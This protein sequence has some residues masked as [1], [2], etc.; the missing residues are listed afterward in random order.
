MAIL[1]AVPVVEPIA[2]ANIKAC[3]LQYRQIA[4]CTNRGKTLRKGAIELPCIDMVGD[5][6]NELGAAAW[7]VTSRA[8]RMGGVEPIQD[9]SSVQE[10]VDQ[11][12]QQRSAARQC[13]AI[14]AEPQRRQSERRTSP[15]P[16]LCP[17]S[18][19]HCAMARSSMVIAQICAGPFDCL[20]HSV[21]DPANKI[22]TCNV[23]NKQA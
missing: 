10:I 18:R 22:V 21:I 20:T 7:P 1:A 3:W 14:V 12:Y 8:I 16:A 15:G 19:R 13:R 11:R 4:S 6:S 5:Q 2:V 23:A 9:P 17:K